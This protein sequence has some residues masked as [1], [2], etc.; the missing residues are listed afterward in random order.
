MKKINKYKYAKFC[1][2]GYKDRTL[3]IHHCWEPQILQIHI[4]HF[5][6]SC[7]NFLRIL[8]KPYRIKM[9]YHHGRNSAVGRG[10]V[11]QP[12][13]VGVTMEAH[14]GMQSVQVNTTVTAPESTLSGCWIGHVGL[15]NWPPQ[16]PDPN[17]H[18][19]RIYAYMKY[20][21]Y[22]CMVAQ[23]MS[24]TEMLLLVFYIPLWN[25]QEYALK[26]NANILNICYISEGPGYAKL[27]TISC[28]D[29]GVCHILK[30]SNF[31]IDGSL[32]VKNYT[33]VDITFFTHND[34]MNNLLKL[35]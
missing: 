21:V 30:S 7:H 27:C 8:L 12:K 11:S 15:Y 32:T 16:S 10:M 31:P 20:L 23:V 18:D 9:L 14:T 6:T 3:H 28:F 13:C 35:W 19:F 33:H 1:L 2:L 29:K 17:T 26:L 24:M 22:E 25:I 4:E 34:H 5:M